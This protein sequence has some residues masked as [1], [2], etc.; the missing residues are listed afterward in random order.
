MPGITKT[1]RELD[2]ELYRLARAEAV[3]EGKTIGTWLNEAIRGKLEK[4]NK[5]K[6]G[7]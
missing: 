4:Q 2:P 3:K 7:K 1:I 5:K 6:G